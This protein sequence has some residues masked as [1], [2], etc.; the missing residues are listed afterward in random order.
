MSKLGRDQLHDPQIWQILSLY[1]PFAG[2]VVGR[3]ISSGCSIRCC[4][5]RVPRSIW[6]FSVATS[7]TRSWRAESWGVFL[8]RTCVAGPKRKNW[9]PLICRD[10]WKNP[11]V[12]YTRYRWII[13]RG[14]YNPAPCKCFFTHFRLD[15]W[16]PNSWRR[17][18][19]LSL[20]METTFG[21]IL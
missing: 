13:Q 10:W 5:K 1:M 15:D 21:R 3:R 14:K 4:A 16:Q 6:A 20:K 9:T 8:P 2:V 18:F 11:F 19:T 17:N 12:S 7:T